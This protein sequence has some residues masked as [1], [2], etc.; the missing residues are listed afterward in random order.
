V[1]R[2]WLLAAAM[3]LAG[4]RARTASLPVYGYMP[5]FSLTAQTGRPFD[6]RALAG[7]IWVANFMFSSCTGPCPRMSSQIRRLGLDLR[8]L[9]QVRFISFTV[10]PARDTPTALAAYASRYQADPSRWLFL[11]GPRA[12]LERL[13]RGAFRL[14][15]GDGSLMH[16]TRLVLVD[17]RGRIRGYYPTDEDG[18]IERLAAG[19]RRLAREA[20]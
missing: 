8:D 3:A 15:E 9:P 7:K 17:G 20:S 11:T 1:K 2:A 10:D 19:L 6:S 14:G 18:A 5:D 4:C 12:E 16:S 13:D